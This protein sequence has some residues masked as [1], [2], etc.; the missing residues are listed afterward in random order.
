[1]ST[2]VAL[3]QAPT[4][5]TGAATGVG[6]AGATVN[7]SV[8]ANG[9]STT[10]S[11]EYGLT[12]EYG[13]TGFADQSPVTGS[14]DTPVTATLVSL[15]SNTTYHY[16]VV[17]TNSSGTT[18][19]ADMTF[20]TTAPSGSSPLAI[21]DPATGIGADFAT[22]NGRV[23]TFSVSTTVTFEWGLDTN[24]GNTITADQS[25]VSSSALD[26]VTATL[27]GLATNTTYHYR[28]VASNINGTSYGL[29]MTFVIGSAGSSPSATTNAATGIGA[30]AATLNGTVNANGMASTVTFEYGLDTSYGSSAAASPSPVSGSTDTAVALTLTDLLPNTTYHFRVVATNTNGTTNGADMTYTTLPLAP[31]ATTLA[32]SAVTTTGATLNGTVN[33]NGSSTTVTFEYGLTTSYGTTV[34]ADQSPVTGFTDAAVSA[35]ISGLT[36]GITYHY[37]VVAVNAGG[38]IYGADMVFTAGTLPPSATTDAASGIGTTSATLNGT[39]NANNESTT[40]TFEYGETIAYGRTASAVQSPVAGSTNTAVNV[41]VSDLL[42]NVTYH[43][44]VK[45]ESVGGTTYGADMSFSTL[46][47][48]TA[49]TNPAT[50]VSTSGATLNGTVNANNDST[51][52]TFEYG[53]TLAYG[54]TVTA[55]QSPV[56]GASSTAVSRAITGL[57]SDTTYH[58]R[59]VAQNSSGTTYGADMTLF[60]GTAPPTAATGTASSVGST[61]ATLNGTV[62][63][64]NGSTTVTF[65]YGETTGYGRT[66]TAD[67]SPVT[68]STDTAVSA[69]VSSLN[70]NTT[71]HF[72]VV[73]QNASGTTYGADMTFATASADTAVVVTAPVT[74]VTTSSAISGGDVTEEGNAPVTARGVCWSTAPA[75]TIADTC[76]SDGT[77]AGPFTSNITGL[78]PGTTYYVRAYATNAFGTVYGN[79]IGFAAILPIPTLSGWGMIIL[80]VLTIGSALWFMRRRFK[81]FG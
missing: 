63:A 36:N 40:V 65:E 37:R 10:V 27:T 34:T 11:F 20:T 69:N 56:I 70:P 66:A 59:V 53:T 47:A 68:G 28:V 43:F 22:L 48:P 50:A 13:A 71:Y 45:A 77:G 67:Q 21:T 74:G 26:P 33:A 49:T 64:N 5:T 35:A 73:G 19:G 7:G 8:N 2:G 1:V 76:T 32:A 60:T 54:T 16:R 41:T 62:N 46:A 4:A 24:Y 39:V 57:S 51:T 72:R 80:S 29:D 17:A 6:S 75:P 79:E 12:T 55:D 38:T 30:T 81:V 44:R 31:T 25:P 9:S 15:N 14:T 78:T 23:Y 52:V 18:Y 61:S 58:Y 42:P 3:A